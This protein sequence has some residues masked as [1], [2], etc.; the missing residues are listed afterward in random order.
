MAFGM[1]EQYCHDC[2]MP[3]EPGEKTTVDAENRAYHARHSVSSEEAAKVYVEAFSEALFW[4]G[5]TKPNR[6][7]PQ[8]NR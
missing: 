1:F 2:K 6:N 5:G 8:D 4:F 3:I 7:F